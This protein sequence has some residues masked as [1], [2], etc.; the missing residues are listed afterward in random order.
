[1][2]FNWKI[3]AIGVVSLILS[4]ELC[5]QIKTIDKRGNTL[6]F[7]FEEKEL[8]EQIIVAEENYENLSSQLEILQKELDKTRENISNNS[9][10]KALEEKIKQNN[11]LLGLTEVTGS[12]IEITIE[13]T[14]NAIKEGRIEKESQAMIHD[15]D[16]M[17]I[18]NELKAAGAEAIE[19]NGKR[20]TNSSA[21]TCEG[22]IIKINR[23]RV[24][25]PF[26]IK[27]IG[28]PEKLAAINSYTGH[29]KKELN[30]YYG[31]K[32][33]LKKLEKVTISKS[34]NITNL[35]YAS[36]NI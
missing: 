8:R 11:R 1:M 16:L 5:I 15:R 31:F 26:T 17:L 35:K 20:I 18:V 22:S 21:I 9:E 32:T 25:A 2:K 29:L 3:L 27:A 7:N 33:T 36:P 30:E 13:E 12:G 4:I 14:L 19:I 6:G 34:N 10:S 24:G 23:E 28:Q